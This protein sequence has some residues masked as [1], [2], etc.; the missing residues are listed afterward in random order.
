MVVLGPTRGV[1][2]RNGIAQYESVQSHLCSRSAYGA[3]VHGMALD[4]ERQDTRRGVLKNLAAAGWGAAIGTVA[5]RQ[6]PPWPSDPGVGVP[7]IAGPRT[8]DAVFNVRDQGA[9]GDGVADDT[10][11]VIRPIGRG[12]VSG[13][14]VYLPRG[15]FR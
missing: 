3:P 15:A 4:D 5:A 6:F 1:P 12:L 10:G 8:R 13:G 11:A 7:E 2:A 14:G 9:G